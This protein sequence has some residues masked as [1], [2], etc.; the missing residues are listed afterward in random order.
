LASVARYEEAT[1]G[2]LVYAERAGSG[3]EG[4]IDLGEYGLWSAG[5]D[6]LPSGTLLVVGPIELTSNPGT[7]RRS[8]WRWRACMRSTRITA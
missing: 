2:D 4:S 3:W 8:D 7:I 1:D 5:I 6:R